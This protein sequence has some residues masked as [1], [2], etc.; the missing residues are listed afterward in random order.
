MKVAAVQFFATPFAL[1]RNLQTAERLV[2]EAVSRGAQLVILPEL[3]N[4]GYVYTS[5]LPAASET[6][7]GPTASWLK[8][9]SA[10]LRV[11]VGGAMLIRREAVYNEF[12][13][14]EPDGEI[15]RYCKQHPFL[16]ERFY[17]RAGSEPAIVETPIGRLGLLICWDIAFR[18]AW[19]AY[20]GKV[21]A[22]LI[23]SA[24]PRF[25]R[26]VLNFPEARK[27]YVAELLPGLLR[28]REAIDNW[29]SAEVGRGAALVG[30]PVIHS[31]MA[32]RFVTGI[33]FP[34]LSFAMAAVTKPRFWSW[35]GAA[36]RATLRATFYG[37]SAVFDVRG[38]MLAGVA[39]EEGL[40]V[41]EV[42]SAVAAS[43]DSATT[44]NRSH[45]L[46]HVPP[47][48]EIMDSLLSLL[49]ANYRPQIAK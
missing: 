38:G 44:L 21:D 14:V 18:S 12:V 29:Y 20:R 30:A 7:D 42:G 16:W 10:E 19:E 22:V 1:E 4:T 32:G 2:R 11:V 36:G 39:E 34:R 25:H 3:F 41:A 45:F 46:P 8:G 9:L 26:A 17:F 48:L 37:C 23:S 31:V 5:R 24:P 43:T 49:T 15:H 33:P 47:Q 13:L 35:A 40:A 28:H 6:I 27:V